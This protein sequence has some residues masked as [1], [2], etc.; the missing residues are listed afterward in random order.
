MPVVR[1]TN[2]TLDAIG[3]LIGQVFLLSP[4]GGWAL[5][6]MFGIAHREIS[7]TV[8]ALGFWT[9]LGLVVLGSCVKSAVAPSIPGRE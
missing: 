5:M 8:P 4:L 1:T 3:L 2:R 7:T 9:C 6:L